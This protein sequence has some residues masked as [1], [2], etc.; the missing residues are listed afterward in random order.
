MGM[1]SPFSDLSVRLD[2]Y[3]IFGNLL[4]WFGLSLLVFGSGEKGFQR[5]GNVP[6][7]GT[8]CHLDWSLSILE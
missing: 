8:L 6:L 7:S 2:E 4:L 1:G 5:C 3:P